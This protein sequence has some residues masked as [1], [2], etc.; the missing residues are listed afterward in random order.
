MVERGELD[1]SDDLQKNCLWFCFNKL[2]QQGLDQVRTSWKTHYIRR[3][4][5]NTQAGVPD[6]MYFLPESIGARNCKF[7][8][9]NEDINAMQAHVD[10]QSQDDYDI[11]FE[12]ICQQLSLPDRSQWTADEAKQYFHRLMDTARQYTI[13]R[14]HNDIPYG[15]YVTAATT[16]L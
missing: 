4:R 15:T 7:L 9:D 8:T 5:Y 12:E 1:T 3:S 2:L 11:Y 14:M 13:D 10:Y 16:M 6:Q